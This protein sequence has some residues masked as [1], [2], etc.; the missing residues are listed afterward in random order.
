MIIQFAVGTSSTIL[1][2]YPAVITSFSVVAINLRFNELIKSSEVKS[3]W[4]T[5][6]FNLN[7]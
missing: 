1:L 2:I 5:T 6:S 3:G 4:S 7:V